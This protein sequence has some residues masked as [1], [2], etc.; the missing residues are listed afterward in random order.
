MISSRVWYGAMKWTGSNSNKVHPSVDVA[1]G[2]V[3]GDSLYGDYTSTCQKVEEAHVMAMIN[4][5]P[6]WQDLNS[7]DNQIA[8]GKS[9]SGGTEEEEVGSTFG[10]SMTISAGFELE[11]FSVGASFGTDYEQSL[12]R[13]W[14]HGSS[15][16]TENGWN[17]GEGFVAFKDLTYY[18][19]QYQR[20]GGGDDELARV[21]V[22]VDH[23]S[24][25]RL[26]SV[27]NQSEN[28]GRDLFPTTWVP[29]YRTAWKDQQAIA[30]LSSYFVS[31]D[32][33][34]GEGADAYDFN[35]N[36]TPDYLFAVI[37]GKQ[38][39][40]NNVFYRIGYDVNSEGIPQ[41]YSSWIPIWHSIGNFSSGLGA[42][43]TELN[44][45]D[46]PELVV[47]WVDNPSGENSAGYRVCWDLAST[48]KFSSCGESKHIPGHIGSST[49][50][51]GLEIVDL[52]GNGQP[53]MIFGWIDNPTDVN[54][55][56]YR[57]GWDV[58]SNG[59]S[60][61]WW[62]D[63]KEI[64]GAFG[65]GNAG[66]GLTVDDLDG[67]GQ[68]DLAAA[69]VRSPKGANEWAYS[70]GEDLDEHADV[71]SWSPG[72]RVPGSVGD[73]T[74]AASL[75]SADL[76]TDDGGPELIV[77]WIDNPSTDKKVYSRVGK[78]WELFGGEVNQRPSDL[79]DDKA[80]DGQFEIRLFDQWWNVDGK[81]LWRWDETQGNE[82]I[83]VS[84]G[85][86]NPT[87]SVT[88][89]Q[90]GSQTQSTSE[91]YD[92][93]VGGEVNVLGIGV[94]ASE[95]WGFEEGHSYTIS[96]DKGFYM[97]GQSQ[98]LP[99]SAPSAKEYKYTPFTYMQQAM[100]KT[101]VEHAYMVLDYFVNYPLPM[102]LAS[103]AASETPAFVAGA[104]PV[105]LVGITPAV[106][107]IES[108]TH[109]DSEAWHVTDTATLTWAQPDGDPAV[110][111]GY[112]WYLDHE[113][114]TVP[115]EF[116]QNLAN[117]TTYEGLSD[118]LWYLHV[119]ARGDGGDW[120]ETAHRSVRVDMNPPQVEINPD[121]P[122]PIHN[123]GWYNKAVTFSI[124]A[125]D[126]SSSS[127]QTGSGVQTV[128]F[129]TDG[130]VWQPY[131][132]PL[133][134]DA[135]IPLTS[136]WARAT[137]VVGHTS[138]LVSLTFGVDLSAPSSVV[139]PGCWAANGIY[140]RG[141]YR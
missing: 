20:T 136:L 51:A 141:A 93:T 68:L 120:S 19:Y 65:P 104:I 10:S 41:T 44:G 62:T 86:A 81:L 98:A 49:N 78:Y 132:D 1:L 112:R 21:S 7:T 114:D 121:L 71:D 3:N 33:F 22:P 133:V 16:T 32:V 84:V 73:K 76:V 58:D 50:G 117:T 29:A 17:A 108:P 111:D 34:Y 80:D 56:F 55:G 59:D 122:Y 70:V 38:N 14:T 37:A 35:G 13:S 57:V 110:V 77:G 66:L 72:H 63:P 69:W 31:D 8:Y 123:E 125:T 103:P 124:D 94:E 75:A 140:C 26:F 30:S 135:E 64:E 45:N 91:S 138:E 9:I 107:L 129:S 54:K 96:W 89:D 43:V 40:G 5:P 52:N 106:P 25:T 100:S 92:F 109:P 115:S 127:G 128:E 42:A 87:W 90:Y 15:T 101:G 97:E 28:G 74:A 116:S 60:S 137:D 53:E 134:F 83:K 126:P 130:V 139:D 4:L 11:G 119:R 6:Y 48:G 24:D 82:P 105:E 67:N 118:G 131:T 99:K 18:V 12:S 27:W 36:G 2:D 79:K 102:A 88:K 23:A 113:P 95:T 85:A 47:A 61:D 46:T 39:A